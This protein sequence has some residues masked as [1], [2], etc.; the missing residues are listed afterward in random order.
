MKSANCISHTGRIPTTAHDLW[1]D[2]VVTPERIIRP[3][4]HH[5]Q[6]GQVHWEELTEEKFLAIPLLARLRVQP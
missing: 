2:L 3:P 1:V 6:R 5:R 4:R